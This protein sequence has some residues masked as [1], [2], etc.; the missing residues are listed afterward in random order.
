MDLRKAIGERIA[1]RRTE[2][3]WSQEDLAVRLQVWG[4]SSIYQQRVDDFEKGKRELRV[5]QLVGF[6]RV[7]RVPISWLLGVPDEGVK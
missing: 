3:G 2:L 1:A 4:L 6:A 7:L 5:S